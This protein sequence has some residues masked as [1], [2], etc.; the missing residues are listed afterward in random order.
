MDHLI[1]VLKTLQHL[2]NMNL[3]REIQ[4]LPRL[5][6]KIE[7]LKFIKEITSL[8]IDTNNNL[9]LTYV[10][11]NN[12][13]LTQ[14][15][16]LSTSSGFKPNIVV[17][18]YTELLTVTGQQLFEFVE[19]QNSQGTQWLPGSIG[20]TYYGS[21][22]YYWNGTEWKHDNDKI[23]EALQQFVDALALIIPTDHHSGFNYIKATEDITVFEDK[24]MLVSQLTIDGS[25]TIN[26]TTTVI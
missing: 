20:G 12:N 23:Y 21:G 6:K 11:G 13:T 24:E 18:N 16:M 15:V 10:D 14:E 25:L 17:D 19:V 8:T 5:R 1:L 22:L 4:N 2:V 9:I 26:G 7:C 3:E